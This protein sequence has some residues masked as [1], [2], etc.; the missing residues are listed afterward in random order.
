[1]TP[2]TWRLIEHHILSPA[3]NL[4]IDEA[5]QREV[6]EGRSPDTLRLWRS[7]PSVVVG[8]FQDWGT[9]VDHA[10]CERMGIE[11]VRRVS[12]GG[13]VYHD[14]GNLNYSV[15]IRR[16]LAPVPLDG[17]EASMVLLCKGMVE[18]LSGLDIMATAQRGSVFAGGRKLSG[19]AQHRMHG[20][21]LHHGTL[22]IDVDLAAL[23]TS[24]REPYPERYLVNLR[25]LCPVAARVDVVT[26]RIERGFCRALGV[27]LKRGWLTQGELVLARELLDMKYGLGDWKAPGAPGRFRQSRGGA[28]AVIHSLWGQ[29]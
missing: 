25:D 3:M 21:V 23:S 14:L 5:I 20:T 6:V 15:V 29:P 11:V 1:M 28:G 16:S 26:T 12:G 2:H 22:M 4:A 7:P 17:V 10:A 27:A 9:S 24:L 13:A 19:S 18:G 8:Y